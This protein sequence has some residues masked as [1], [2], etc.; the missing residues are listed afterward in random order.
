MKKDYPFDVFVGLQLLD[1][2]GRIVLNI[3]ESPQDGGS[4]LTQN[5]NID[6]EIIG[7]YGSSDTNDHLR[8]IGFVLW[9]K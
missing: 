6:E 2:D 4:W 5:I 3:D 7:I 8:S 9:S 1:A